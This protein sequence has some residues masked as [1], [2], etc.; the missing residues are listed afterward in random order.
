MDD[1]QDPSAGGDFLIEKI[2]RTQ[3]FSMDS[4]HTHDSYEIYYLLD[5]ERHYFIKDRTYRVRRGD[6]VLIPAGELHQTLQ[7]ADGAHERILINFRAG[8]IRPFQDEELNYDAVFRRCPVLALN[9]REQMTVEG[10]LQR[11]LD[12]DRLRPQGWRLQLRLSL[13]ELLLFLCRK[14]GSAPAEPAEHPNPTFR[15]V[16]EIARYIGDHYGEPL[17]LESLSSLFHIS[18]YY[19]SRTFKKVTGFGLVEYM[20]WVRVK[21]AQRLLRTTSLPITEVSMRSGFDSIT[22]FGRVFKELCGMPP[23]TYRSRH[24]DPSPRRSGNTPPR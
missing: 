8:F 18:P 22:H 17:S 7:A 13:A 10:L 15:K 24:A 5:G 20:H 21:E 3:A 14:C 12:E 6:L 11:M 9:A 19:L 16:S 2:K 1:R 4:H 23:R